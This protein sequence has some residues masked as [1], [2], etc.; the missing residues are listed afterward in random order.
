MSCVYL[1]AGNGQLPVARNVACPE[2]VPGSVTSG[3]TLC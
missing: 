1:G 3:I 2:A